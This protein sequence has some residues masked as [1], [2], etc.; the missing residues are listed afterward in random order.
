MRADRDRLAR[1]RALVCAVGTR[2]DVQPIFALALRL[3]ALGHD[4]RLCVPPNF[5]EQ[6]RALGFDA[7]AVGV[8]MRARPAA[9]AAALTPDE[10]KR[11]LAS[12]PDLVSDQFDVVGAAAEGCD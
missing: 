7:C 9:G 10:M 5:V 6:A 1:M 8:E 4:A 3:R 12:L 2:G 11:I